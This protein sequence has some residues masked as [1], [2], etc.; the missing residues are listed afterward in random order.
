MPP[1]SLGLLTTPPG[2]L[3]SLG[4]LALNAQ[5]SLHGADCVN[6][7]VQTPLAEVL[8]AAQD[9]QAGVVA[10]SASVC[11]PLPELLNYL[12]GLRQA[13]PSNCALWAGGA[14]CAQLAQQVPDGCTVMTD[15]A[16]ALQHWLDLAKAQR[17]TH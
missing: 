1:R 9:M 5:L 4:L 17:Y 8:Q 12:T 13:L 16:M 15:T 3:H 7:G 11:L 2:E 6:L 14:G 10:I